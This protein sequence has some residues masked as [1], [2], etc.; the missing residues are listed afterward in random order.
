M[1]VSAIVP[2]YNEASRIGAVLKPLVSSSSVD[3]V[4]VV[5]DGSDDGTAEVAQ[6]FP[7]QVVKLPE[8]CGKAKALDEGVVRARNDVLLFLDA[9]LVGL[10]KEHVDKFVHSYEESGVDMAVGVFAN[11]R[12]NTDFAQK[13][14]PYASGQRMLT[15]KLWER[16]KANV[17]EMNYGIEFALSKLAVKEGWSKEKVKLEG[18]T[19]VLK[20]EKRGFSNGMRERLKM[21][22]DM[23]KWLFKKI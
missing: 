4:I 10:T 9:D 12:K 7:V 13:F 8:N 20:E 23:I 15:K 5:D 16:A 1:K 19:H 18:V 14:N 3:E 17:H 11:G 2:A 22:G 21:Y 6:D